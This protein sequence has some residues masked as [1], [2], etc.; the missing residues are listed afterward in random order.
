[1]FAN[2][3]LVADT[4]DNSTYTFSYDFLSGAR[5]SGSFDGFV[6]GENDPIFGGTIVANPDGRVLATFEDPTGVRFTWDTSLPTD[7]S[8]QDGHVNTA[9]FSFL[10]IDGSK[11]DFTLTSGLLGPGGVLIPE[12]F[13]IAFHNGIQNHGQLNKVS[14]RNVLANELTEAF[15]PDRW[16]LAL[17][18]E[19]S[20]S[21][22]L[23][24]AF[25]TMLYR[26]RRK[27]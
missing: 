18:P 10:S 24:V 6:F 3:H 25:F 22:V 5:I 20:M 21:V 15:I 17:V 16:K 1:M 19:P 26:R 14:V 23:P 12:P 2:V 27:T 4:F 9:E 8:S 11:M 7:A 13:Q